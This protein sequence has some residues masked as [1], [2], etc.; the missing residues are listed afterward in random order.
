MLC[1]A[2]YHATQEEKTHKQ[3]ISY[4]SFSIV[5]N[6]F[7]VILIFHVCHRLNLKRMYGKW[8]KHGKLDVLK[9]FQIQTNLS[10]KFKPMWAKI[11]ELR[12]AWRKCFNLDIIQHSRTTAW[13]YTNSCSLVMALSRVNFSYHCDY[14]T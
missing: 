10:R 3:I 12:N 2:T 4:A 6:E 14:I 13:R 11:K 9:F 7:L 8:I 5:F 1:L